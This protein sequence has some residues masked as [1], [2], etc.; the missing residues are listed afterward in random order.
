MT[1]DAISREQNNLESLTKGGI[2]QL[3][4]YIPVQIVRQF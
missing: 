3:A 1:W 2:N 4:A